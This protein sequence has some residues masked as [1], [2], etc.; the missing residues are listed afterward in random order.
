MATFAKSIEIAL[1]QSSRSYPLRHRHP[2]LNLRSDRV[3]RRRHLGLYLC[4][5]WVP[6][7]RHLGLYLYSDRVTPI[8][9]IRTPTIIDMITMDGRLQIIIHKMMISDRSSTILPIT[10]MGIVGLTTHDSLINPGICL[11]LTDQFL[12]L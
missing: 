12:H 10:N 3:S 5:E 4:S 9:L 8:M 2:S 7:R 11:L 6:Q 1:L